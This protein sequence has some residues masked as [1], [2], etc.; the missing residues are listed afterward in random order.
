LLQILVKS[1]FLYVARITVTPIAVEQKVRR[2]EILGVLPRGLRSQHSPDTS[3][4]IEA[5]DL[6]NEPLG[7]IGPPKVSTTGAFIDT[8]I[9]GIE[10][11]PI[12]NEELLR[13]GRIPRLNFFSALDPLI[14]R[15]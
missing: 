14:L 15:V 13:I 3:L 6:A 5:A 2:E 9:H 11:D 1:A 4:R 10:S 8:A 12:E 7:V